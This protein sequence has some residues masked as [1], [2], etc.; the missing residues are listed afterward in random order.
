MSASRAIG[1]ALA[2][3]QL[4]AGRARLVASVLAL[5]VGVA[6][7]VAIHLV[8]ASALAEFD[9]AARALTGQAD[10]TARG[11]R[12]GFDEAVYPALARATAVAAAS[13]VLEVEAALDD[14]RTL[15]VVGVD[16][17]RLGAVQPALGLTLAPEFLGLL[18]PRAIVLS[19]AAA[20]ELNAGP[21]A[22]VRVRI[23]VER[24][25]LTVRAVLPEGALAGP[26]AVMDI[27]SAQLTLGALGRLTRVDLRLKAGED[28]AA[29]RRALAAL[30]PPGVWLATP[31]E[32]QERTRAL[33]RAYRVNLNLLAVVALLTGA[34][35]VYASQ[36]LALERRRTL[37]ALLRAL[38]VR[39]R[40]LFAALAVE[41][42]LLGAAGGALGAGLGWGCAA[43]VLARLGADLGGGYFAGRGA[44]LP[45]GRVLAAAVLAGAA[46]S[47]LGSLWPARRALAVA[48]A[49]ALRG[50]MEPADGGPGRGRG[51][52]LTG[53]GAA[54]GALA[55]L[56]VPGPREVPLGGYLSIALLLVAALT[57]LPALLGWAL[58]ALP[59]RGPP[60][61]RL[62]RA[63]L[64]G[65]SV[66][67][68][69][70]VSALLVSFS[71]MVAMAIMVQSFRDSFIRWLDQVVPAELN[72][73]VPLGSTSAAWNE[74][75]QAALAAEAGV[76]R[77]EFR[78]V[79]ALSLAP[80]RPTVA[81]VA[82]PLDGRQVGERLPL[83]AS[84]PVA[85]GALA[86][87]GSEAMAD[88][89]GWRPGTT[90]TLPLGGRAVAVVVGGIYRDY[91][92]SF[93]TIAID[94][95]R[96]IE[97]TGDASATE[98][99]VWLAPGA[100]PA[101]VER[102]LRARLGAG[103]RYEVLATPALKARSLAL[104]DRAFAVT[105]VLEAVA[106]GMGLLGVGLVGSAQALARRAEFG[107]LRHLGLT[108]GDLT[109][110][111][112]LEGAAQGLAAVAG[113]LAL[114]GL[115]SLVLVHVVNRRSFHWSLDL[116]LPWRELAL[117]SLLVVAAAALTAA[118]AARAATG[119]GALAAVRADA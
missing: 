27:G 67:A 51:A 73:R 65:E 75:T 18:E 68:S 42:A 30:L 81:L 66:R 56:G 109:R 1:S 54:L 13:P 92:R 115:E 14:G 83:V 86:V 104:F 29:A 84:A 90:I 63:A 69:L 23:G 102:A 5:A 89:Y 118:L 37:L 96:Y 33:S 105:Y 88:L 38:G 97:V 11:P 98:A 31:D 16:P 35:L 50:G 61:V 116:S 99:G 113:G 9:A 119:E 79:D 76:A 12:A 57:L 60:V 34:F 77:I 40:E 94:R 110:M 15:A 80:D 49:Q 45:D 28:R 91:A 22:V 19:F 108:R 70:G 25:P 87:Y 46:I 62:A 100:S 3:A 52:L 85:P 43:L 114:G 117:A 64:A 95:A 74:A 93:G 103:G 72:L 48:P 53:T 32:E 36:A 58:A 20:A 106:V 24:V 44:A 4:A 6:L 17:L 39:R 26:V 2:A 47:V 78:R 55:A 112:A 21:G 10:L 41:G 107:V 82:R 101:A 71:L 59:A 8:N 111:L 7:V